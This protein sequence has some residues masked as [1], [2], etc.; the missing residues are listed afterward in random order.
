MAE[1]PDSSEPDS[2][3]GLSTAERPSVRKP[4]RYQ[5]VLHNDNYTTMEFVVDILMR[6]FRKDVAEA[7]HI[8]L[9]VHRKGFGVVDTFPRDVAE[10]KADQVMDLAKE[11]GHPLRCTAEPESTD[12]SDE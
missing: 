6:L 1:R 4:R 9:H 3:H 2:E 10:T 7:Q 11:A 8:M 12:S 5:V